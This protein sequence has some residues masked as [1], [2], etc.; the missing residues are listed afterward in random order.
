[1]EPHIY[2]VTLAVDDLNRA[3]AF[4]REGLGFESPGVIGAEFP[5][6]H[7]HPSG[8]VAMFRL[9]D[10]LILAVWP[11]SELAKDASVPLQPPKTAEFSIASRWPAA[12]RS[13]G[14]SARP[15]PLA[16]P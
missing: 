2:V 9:H 13:T 16:P 14:S 11:R 1:M 8:A 15:K 3:L 10:G 6:D 12:P 5:G 7:A 4:Y